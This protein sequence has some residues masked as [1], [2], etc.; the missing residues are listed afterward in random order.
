[1]IRYRYNQQVTPPAPFV[2]VT[3]R[4]PEQAHVT[5][6]LPAQLDSAASKSVIPW[7]LIEDLELI[8]LDQILIEGVGG[9]ITS[10]P[11]FLVELEI[12]QLHPVHVEV[13]ANK[14]EPYVLLGR[15]IM[16]HYHIVLDGPRLQLEIG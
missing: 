10:M 16:N 6:E 1:M 12:R 8:E 5:G 7:N 2:Y 9:H 11:S 14:D 4:S 15:D 3:V 13:V